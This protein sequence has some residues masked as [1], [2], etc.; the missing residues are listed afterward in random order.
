MPTTTRT[1]RTRPRSKRLISRAMCTVGAE[2]RADGYGPGDGERTNWP[3]RDFDAMVT[4]Q[5]EGVC[6]IGAYLWWQKVK[7]GTD[8]AEAFAALPTMADVDDGDLYT[9]ADLAR[10]DAGVVFSLAWDLAYMNDEKFQRLSP[11]ERW[12]KFMAWLDTELGVAAV[13]ASPAVADAVGER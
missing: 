7:E 9:T 11:E 13:L 6:A 5:G 4:E 1:S 2:A 8:P 10:R 12:A 3:R